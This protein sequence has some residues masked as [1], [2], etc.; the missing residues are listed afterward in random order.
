M[1]KIMSLTQWKYRP[2]SAGVL[3]VLMGVTPVSVQ[4]ESQQYWTLESSIERVVKVAP[5]SKIAAANIQ[6]HRGALRQAGAW[7]NPTVSLQMSNKIG[8][9][10]GTGGQDLTQFALTQP[11]PLFGQRS[12]KKSIARARLKASIAQGDYQYLDLERKISIRFHRLQFAAAQ[13]KL[14]QERLAF[15]TELKDVGRKREQSG[16]MAILERTRLDLVR[17]TAKQLA[18]KAEG[19]YN[20]TL[21]Q[22]S[23]LLGLPT[24]SLP[25][26]NSLSPITNLPPLTA[27]LGT[28]PDHPLMEAADNRVKGAKARVA[29]AKAD[30]LPKLFVNMYRERDFLGGR[31]QNSHGVGLSFT[32]PLW[33]RQ[34]GRI[35]E[36]RARVQQSYADVEIL[37]RDLKSSVRQNYLH[38]NH[39]IEQGEHYQLNVYQPSQ[40]VFEMT[41]KAYAAG[42]VEIL[43]LIDANNIYFD[44]QT[45]YLELLQ[46]AWLEAAELRLAAG[47]SIFTTGQDD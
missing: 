32:V 6:A 21:S 43:S 19:E 3:T 11:V 13:Y 29:L 15:A 9:D 33:D 14:E 10:D 39:L 30:R 47:Q 5:E 1:V 38:L 22:F 20:E 12:Q 7:K 34:G 25:Q 18:D 4:A 8:L 42:E 27:Y 24:G 36:T 44:A 31:V 41:R 16:D 35:T 26:L 37:Q 40:R 23:A 28:L 45:G 2:L 46:D 17:E